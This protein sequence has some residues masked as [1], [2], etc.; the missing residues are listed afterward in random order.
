MR[1]SRFLAIPGGT[2]TFRWCGNVVA[3][4]IPERHFKTDASHHTLSSFPRKRCTT[5]ELV[6]R[7]SF[8]FP[9]QKQKWIPA[10]A[11]MTTS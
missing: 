5:P 3:T 7:E 2:E 8:I 4:S 10:F 9:Q 6:K 11:G 1:R